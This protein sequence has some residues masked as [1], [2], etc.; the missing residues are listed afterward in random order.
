MKTKHLAGL[1]T[2]LMISAAAICHA[3]AGAL[4]MIP[5]EAGGVRRARSRA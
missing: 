5:K 1:I 2:V 4:I 3:K